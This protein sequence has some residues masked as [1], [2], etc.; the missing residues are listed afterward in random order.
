MKIIW[1]LVMILF[2]TGC[3]KNFDGEYYLLVDELQKVETSTIDIPFD[4]EISLDKITDDEIMYNIIVDNPKEKTTGIKV[5][6]IHN[7]TTKDIYP[8]I[9]IFDNKVNLI[10][11]EVDEKKDNV[12][13]IALV[14]YLPFDGSIDTFKGVFKVLIE[15]TNMNGSLKKIYFIHKF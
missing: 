10:P 3:G 13:G 5:L 7:K 6:V 1:A 9:G 4:I 14:G 15:Y 2:I 11:N 12:K 8:S